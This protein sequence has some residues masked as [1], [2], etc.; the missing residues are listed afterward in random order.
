MEYSES[1]PIIYPKWGLYAS[2]PDQESLDAQV[3][4][5]REAAPGLG[6]T[7]EPAMIRGEILSRTG[8]DLPERDDMLRRSQAGEF[9]DI[10]VVSPYDPVLIDLQAVQENEKRMFS[11]RIKQGL[12][13]AAKLGS[14]PGGTAPF[15]YDRDP[16]TK[17]WRVNPVEAPVVQRMFEMAAAGVTPG[18]IAQTLNESGIPTRKNG[19][20]TGTGVARILKNRLRTGTVNF[21]GIRIEII[22]IVG[23][24]LLD[25]VQRMLGQ[26]RRGSTPRLSGTFRCGAFDRNATPCLLAGMLRC[27]RCGERMTSTRTKGAR[28]Y[29]C[30]GRD[31]G[32]DAPVIDAVELETK[33]LTNVRELLQNPDGIAQSFRRAARKLDGIDL[34]GKRQVLKELG[35]RVTVEHSPDGIRIRVESSLNPNGD[36]NP[37]VTGG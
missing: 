37:P 12:E 20:W 24:V 31:S 36:V 2:G 15:G 3:Q 25:V 17:T 16:A 7:H 5:L 13:R 34:R 10:V 32:C 19:R 29:C 8:A 28:Y 9:S 27:E 26:R 1:N 4:R 22:P 6:L 35:I 18:E 11:Q 14:L 33:V 30:R 21:M 23:Q